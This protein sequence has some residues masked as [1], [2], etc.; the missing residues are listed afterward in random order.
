MSPTDDAPATKKDITMLMT[1][2][3]KLYEANERWKDEILESSEQWKNE[4][5]MANEKWKDEIKAHFD[6]VAENIKYDF[7]GAFKDKVEQHEDRLVRLEEHV[8]TTA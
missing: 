3:G 4:I 7:K 5:I 6:F 8:G 2:I 1:E